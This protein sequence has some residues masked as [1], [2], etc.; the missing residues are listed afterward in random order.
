MV[1]ID[2]ITGFLGS[3][4]T[5]FIKKYAKYLIDSGYNIG[6]LENDYGAVNVDMM[7]LQDLMGE[8]C[9]LEMV[10]GG[11][12]K[13]CHRR[14]FKTKLIA[15]GMCGYDRVIVEPSGIFDVDEFFDALR[16][17]PLDRWYE[18]GNVIAIVDAGLPGKM[19][20]DAE[21]LLAS[22]A[23]DAGLVLISKTDRALK[24]QIEDI[25]PHINRAMGSISCTRM[26]KEENVIKKSW[27]EFNKED[28]ERVLSCSHRTESWRKLDVED[29]QAFSSLSFMNLK[30]SEEETLD[31]M[32]RIL[33]D[34]ECG[35][36][37]RIKGFL[38]GRDGWLELNATAGQIRLNPIK[39]GQEILIVIGEK[40]NKKKIEQYFYRIV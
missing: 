35:N 7:L 38:C 28:W 11:C 31:A 14:R 13:D 17:E 24:E 27:D 21:Y 25:L 39:Q 26:L 32:Q 9:E 30:L 4:K 22:E 36:V 12:D 15:M 2:L 10:S 3:G 40:L 8:H 6:I 1:K 16:E 33:L 29:D 34:S 19:S 5:T 37:H 18:I 20:E 23:A